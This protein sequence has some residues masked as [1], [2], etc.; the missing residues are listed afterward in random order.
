[1]LWIRQSKVMPVESAVHNARLLQPESTMVS[2]KQSR[3]RKQQQAAAAA[4]SLP[5]CVVCL[6][7]NPEASR[8]GFKQTWT[9]FVR[10]LERWGRRVWEKALTTFSCF[11]SCQFD[12]ICRS[13][14]RASKKNY[15]HIGIDGHMMSAR[16]P[17][18]G[19]NGDKNTIRCGE[20][21]WLVMQQLSR[22]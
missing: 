1:M 7:G 19:P 20:K 3:W 8:A 22:V 16:Q 2:T 12:Q 10:T 6:C 13:C 18:R 9:P 15:C 5:A 21:N 17:Y 4:G 11:K 14:L